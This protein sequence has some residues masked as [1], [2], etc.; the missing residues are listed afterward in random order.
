MAT[1]ILLLAGKGTRLGETTPKQFIK[2]KDKSLFMYPL[3]TFAKN[4]K[5][6]NILLVVPD[7]YQAQVNEE[8]IEN[9]INKVHEIIIGGKT[10][11][12]SV[13][14]ALKF[15]EDIG[16]NE[17]E[18]ILIH[19]AARVLVNDAIIDKNIEF[20]DKFGAVCTVIPNSDTLF[21]SN[22]SMVIDNVIDRNNVYNAQTPQSFKFSLIQKA[23]KEGKVEATDDAQLML[24]LNQPV[25]IVLG[26][27]FNFKVTT[28]DDLELL[29][30]LL[31]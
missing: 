15:L 30:S 8:I 10:R 3:I 4:P 31:G 19:D 12:E 25:H 16:T 28:S 1:V 26:N 13:A 29:K 7:G 5:I 23:Y 24:K 11:S 6:N 9:K 21:K 27:K 14:H 20:C 2:I 22:D 18:I 17:D